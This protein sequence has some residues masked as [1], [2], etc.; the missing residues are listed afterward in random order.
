[1]TDIANVHRQTLSTAWTTTNPSLKLKLCTSRPSTTCDSYITL[2]LNGISIANEAVGSVREHCEVCT[3]RRWMLCGLY[4]ELYWW[5]RTI[6]AVYGAASLCFHSSLITSVYDYMLVRHRV[7]LA[8]PCFRPHTSVYP[9][10]FL[11]L[12]SFGAFKRYFVAF[13]L[14]FDSDDMARLCLCA[15]RMI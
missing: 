1:M 15:M 3:A 7:A 6:K 13:C 2:W 5:S 14:T 9:S 8:A 4:R 12:V 10:Y 11:P